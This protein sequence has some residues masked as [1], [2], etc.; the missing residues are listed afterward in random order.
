M[1]TKERIKQLLHHGGEIFLVPED[2]RPVYLKSLKEVIHNP[3]TETE[4]KSQFIK[5]SAFLHVHDLFTKENIS[6]T[7]TEARDLVSEMVNFVTADVNAVASLMRLSTH[8]YYTYNHCV[9]VAVYAIALAK[10][11]YLDLSEYKTSV[12]E[13]EPI[14]EL[15]AHAAV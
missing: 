3:G 9:D 8:D 2:Q 7:L 14:G 5:E 12:K 15:F 11:I 4:L 10:K 13:K 6:E 1:L